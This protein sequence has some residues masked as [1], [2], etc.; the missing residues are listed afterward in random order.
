MSLSKNIC[1]RNYE[2]EFLTNGEWF[3]PVYEAYMKKYYSAYIIG[4][5][6]YRQNPF[7]KKIYNVHYNVKFINVYVLL[8][9]IVSGNKA[10]INLNSL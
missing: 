4:S 9:L 2:A 7:W 6:P 3:I 8:T 5:Q 10:V 1:D